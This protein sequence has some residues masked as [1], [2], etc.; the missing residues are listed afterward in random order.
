[1]DLVLHRMPSMRRVLHFLTSARLTCDVNISRRI[2]LL[3]APRGWSSFV[4]LEPD[5]CTTLIA[6]LYL[7]DIV[8][9]GAFAFF[10]KPAS[11]LA[12]FVA[13]P[14]NCVARL[15]SLVTLPY[16]LFEKAIVCA[17]PWSATPPLHSG[18]VV[19]P[20]DMLSSYKPT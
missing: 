10:V 4:G 6:L 17:S 16:V 1:M 8:P 19:L 3:Y 5:S 13:F 9:G 15:I 20:I 12:K 11:F 14:M 18:H 2:G 7:R